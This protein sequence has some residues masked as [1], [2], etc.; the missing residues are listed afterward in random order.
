MLEKLEKLWSDVR[1]VI[2]GDQARLNETSKQPSANRR[3]IMIFS[4][5]ASTLIWF[6]LSLSEYQY[7]SVEY[8]TCASKA[9]I[10]T[11]SCVIGLDADSALT[12]RLPETIQATLYGPGISLI[13]QRFRAR[14]SRN[15]ITINYETGTLD[16]QL[17]LRIPE[18]VTI[19]SIVPERINFQK[20]KR[21]ERKVPIE[22]R[23]TQISRPPYFFIGD[24]QLE[25]DSIL[26]SG[27]ESMIR[28]IKSWP[29]ELDTLVGV[30]DTVYH[31]V[32]LS[33]SL[34]GLVSLSQKRTTLTGISPQYTEGQKQQVKVEIIGIP[35]AQSI[36]QLEPES[37]TI[38]YQVPLSKFSEALQEKRIRALVSYSQIFADTT[39]RIQPT[40]EFPS[41]LML[42]QVTISPNR[43]RYFI[44]IGSQ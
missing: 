40:V 32:D 26:I 29:T 33:D 19:E 17:L 43:L 5:S 23:V 38:T 21:M 12:H 25:P 20:E 1:W 16:T 4:L 18:R 24:L 36:V 39:G 8:P 7:L 28:L 10:I 37:V 22:S 27:P 9:D 41:D 14:Y 11:P 2:L 35:N 44:N 30:N 34:R 13:I 3:R 42:R 31:Q 6:L 15:P